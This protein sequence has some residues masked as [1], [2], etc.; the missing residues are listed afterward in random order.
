MAYNTSYISQVTLPDNNTYDIKDAWAREKLSGLTGAMHFVGVS[1]TDPT[2]EAGPTVDGVSSFSTGDVVVYTPSGKAECEYVYNGTSWQEFGSTGSLKALAFKDS[3]TGSVNGSTFTAAAQTFKGTAATLKHTVNSATVSV[4]GTYKKAKDINTTLS[5]TA[6]ASGAA[7]AL[8][9]YAN[10]AVVDSAGSVSAG[11]TPTLSYTNATVKVVS[12]V[13]TGTPASLGSGFYTAGTKGS[14]PSLT[15][16]AATA[17][18]VSVTAGTAASLTHEAAKAS[19]ISEFSGGSAAS[20]T[21]SDVKASYIS[22]FNGGSAATL[23]YSACTTNGVSSF[24]KGTLPSFK[25][26]SKAAWSA[27]VSGETLSFSWTTNG[28]DT[29]SAGTLPSLTTAVVDASKITAFSGGKAASLTRSDVT[30]THVSAFSGGSAA[31]LTRSDV[32][33]SKI[34]GWTANTPT[35]VSAT[36]VAASKI[37][38]WSAGSATTPASIDVAAFNGG[39]ATSVTTADA[40]VST[41]SAF[42]KGSATSVT[43]P[44][45]SKH[46]GATGVSSV[47]QPTISVANITLAYTMQY[48][49][50]SITS[51]GNATVSIADHSFTPAGTNQSSKVSGTASVTVK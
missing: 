38:K 15:Y 30:A 43:L 49:D 11:T 48:T 8:S 42:S 24:S 44:K 1:T 32:A 16:S 2:L 45:F 25:Q 20:I 27:S 35:A 26:G 7:V 50:T 22:G 51:T 9:T 10:F 39:T 34:T 12:G 33:T 5:T 41:I 23:T 3:A 28:N 47:T 31:S 46:S 4:S 17:S 29:W 13:T 19:Y 14:V 40:V 37:T 36:D 6:T 21:K 18:K